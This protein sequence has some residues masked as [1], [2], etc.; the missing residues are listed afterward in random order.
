VRCACSAFGEFATNDRA[1]RD[2]LVI[3]VEA[4]STFLAGVARLR[5]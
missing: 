4:I 5:V 3:A 2:R 1:V